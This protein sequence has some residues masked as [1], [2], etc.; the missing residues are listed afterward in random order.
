MLPHPLTSRLVWP[1]T[2][3]LIKPKQVRRRLLKAHRIRGKQDAA[4]RRNRTDETN[5]T[6]GQATAD[7]PQE[8]WRSGVTP[9]DDV[10]KEHWYR[11]H[12][13]ALR[14]W[15]EQDG[16]KCDRRECGGARATLALALRQLPRPP[17]QMAGATTWILTFDGGSRGNPGAGG[18]GCALVKLDAPGPHLVW[19]C[20]TYLPAT[21]TTNNVAEI[22]GLL[23]GLRQAWRVGATPLEVIGD[24]NL[25]LGW[26]RRRQ[27]PR[28]A[29]LRWAYDRARH[30]ADR[31]HVTAWT[32]HY[33]AANKTADCLANVAMDNRAS[34]TLRECA[35]PNYQAQAT[36]WKE[37]RA[38]MLSDLEPWRERHLTTRL[39]P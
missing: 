8:R 31:I 37:L 21:M 7:V 25:I 39:P 13:Q 27:P 1:T 38:N 14:P 19:C 18:A 28:K 9:L 23:E 15:T 29:Q 10:D 26:M 36:L 12:Y 34:L 11:L 24:S 6:F 22:R 2:A 20:A 33:R 16:V 35:D 30:F 3:P 4:A 32:H 17:L 5:P